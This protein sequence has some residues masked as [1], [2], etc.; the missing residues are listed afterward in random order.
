[1]SLADVKE[2]MANELW[3]EA[4]N[5]SRRVRVAPAAAH[6]A[7]ADLVVLYE[8]L[9]GKKLLSIVT[10]LVKPG[11]DDGRRLVE[12]MDE[13]AV[14]E[15]LAATATGHVNGEYA[16]DTVGAAVMVP[17]FTVKLVGDDLTWDGSAEKRNP[18]DEWNK[19]HHKVYHG[20]SEDYPRVSSG[21]EDW[22]KP[23]LQPYHGPSEDYRGVEP[24][25]SYSRWSYLLSQAAGVTN[26][27]IAFGAETH[28]A[29]KAG[30]SPMQYARERA[31]LTRK[32]NP[33]RNPRDPKDIPHIKTVAETRAILARIPKKE[34]CDAGCPG[35]IVA[36][37]DTERGTEIEV[38]DECMQALPKAIRLSDD[39]VAQLPEA[40]KEL[41]R[42]E[43]EIGDD[44]R[45]SNNPA[46]EKLREKWGENTEIVIERSAH[47][48]TGWLE[49]SK[50]NRLPISFGREPSTA[51]E[52]MEL[53][54]SFLRK[55]HGKVNP[56]GLVAKRSA[57][58]R[59]DG[60]YDVFDESGKLVGQLFRDPHDREWYEENLP[61]QPQTHYID[62]WR[63]STQVEALERLA[64]RIANRQARQ[65]PT[66]HGKIDADDAR[67]WG[68]EAFEMGL[69]LAEARRQI[70]DA[71]CPARLL[72]EVDASFN[73]AR[74]QAWHREA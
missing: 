64:R 12:S 17:T 57:T 63:G 60:L 13:S 45:Y 74:S 26:A 56:A 33:A 41:A 6:R 50:G 21:N 34:R 69:T 35:W 72:P 44:P 46:D 65:N 22:D 51:R 8:K 43:G 28:D 73:R 11:V 10:L 55:V 2:G 32:R 71:G 5:A 1:M 7:A 19:P 48:Y 39:D 37:T 49:S 24:D 47:G 29:Y 31:R 23:H 3:A 25:M 66:S 4:T 16:K 52:A 53:A 36:E 62:R 9:N 38:C 70:S 54:K 40:Q 42:Q 18:D 68:G 30:K 67:A 58:F 20:P 27:R 15:V 59:D 14:G 61:G